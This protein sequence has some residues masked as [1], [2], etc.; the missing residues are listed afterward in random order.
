MFNFKYSRTSVAESE[1][2]NLDAMSAIRVFSTHLTHA[3]T[4]MNVYPMLNILILSTKLFNS[5]FNYPS[6]ARVNSVK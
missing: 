5:M 3:R 2:V 4:A 1:H 6:I